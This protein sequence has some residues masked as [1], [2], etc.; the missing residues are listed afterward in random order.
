MMLEDREMKFSIRE[1]EA[2]YIIEDLKKQ[3]KEVVVSSKKL[4]EMKR[5]VENEINRA[6]QIREEEEI[7]KFD[8]QKIKNENE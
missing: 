1:K 5:E 7:L 2:E 8:L 4:E 6:R 3:V